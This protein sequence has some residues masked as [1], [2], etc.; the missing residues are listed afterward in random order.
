MEVNRDV[1]LV[2]CYCLSVRHSPL[3]RPCFYLSLVSFSLTRHLQINLKALCWWWHLLRNQELIK[4]WRPLT[5]IS[6]CCF[7]L[8]RLSIQPLFFFLLSVRLSLCTFPPSFS[9]FTLTSSVSHL[10][11]LSQLNNFWKEISFKPSAFLGGEMYRNGKSWCEWWEFG[12]QVCFNL[13]NF[14]SKCWFYFVNCVTSS[15]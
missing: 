10:L 14:S 11:I 12:V 8:L 15:D 7:Y 4:D 3:R 5:S 13:R 2:P 1:C 9:P 6:S